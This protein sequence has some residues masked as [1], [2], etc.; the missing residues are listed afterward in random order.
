VTIIYKGGGTEKQ[1]GIV[2]SESD[3]NSGNALGPLPASGF[4]IRHV[5]R[6]R[7]EKRGR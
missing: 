6:L 4:Y 1:A 3:H 7:L 2:A 5:K